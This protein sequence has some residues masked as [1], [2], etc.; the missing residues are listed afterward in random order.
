MLANC[1]AAYHSTSLPSSSD[2]RRANSRVLDRRSTNEFNSA[3]TTP[4][5]RTKIGDKHTIFT[6]ID[7]REQGAIE[8]YAALISE[9][10]EK[11]GELKRSSKTAQRSANPGEPL[12]ISNIVA[13][14]IAGTHAVITLS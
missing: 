4:I 12:G 1:L 10:A 11:H 3:L 14:E 5:E 9:V 2:N 13:D 6:R 8:L 7:N